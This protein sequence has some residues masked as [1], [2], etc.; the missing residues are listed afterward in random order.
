MTNHNNHISIGYNF[1]SLAIT[2]INLSNGM[3]NNTNNNNQQHNKSNKVLKTKKPTILEIGLKD[4]VFL[5]SK[6]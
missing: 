6:T 3:T 1:E 2:G 4:I 5:D